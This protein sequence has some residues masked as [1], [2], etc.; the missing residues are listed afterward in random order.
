MLL[1]FPGLRMGKSEEELRVKRGFGFF[2]LESWADDG[3]YPWQETRDR[4]R[5]LRQLSYQTQVGSS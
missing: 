4:E 1:S 5:R 3:R 2:R